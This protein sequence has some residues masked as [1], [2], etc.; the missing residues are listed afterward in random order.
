M[1]RAFRRGAFAAEQRRQS[2]DL[3]EVPREEW[4]RRVSSVPPGL[5]RVW[6]SRDWLVQLYDIDGRR[7]LS[8]RRTDMRGDGRASDGITW[9]QLQ[10]IKRECGFGDHWAVEVYPADVDVVDVAAMR[11][12]WLLASAPSFAWRRE[13]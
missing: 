11:H 9:D 13:R 2:E 10:A 1:N 3:V 4:E 7:R 6:R 5:A 12:L 8:I